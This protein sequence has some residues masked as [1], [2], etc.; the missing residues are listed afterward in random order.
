ML[1]PLA[2]WLDDRTGSRR[3]LA[4]A[5][6]LR[7]TAAARWRN[8]IG[9][10]FAILF[11]IEAFTGLL[12][13]LAYSPSSSTA[14]GSVL[15]IDHA[16]WMGWFIRG[17][18]Y[19]AGQAMVILGGLYLLRALWSRAYHRPREFNWW[20]GLILLFLAVSLSR[21][22]HL[23]PWDQEGY[24]STK[25]ETNIA[26]GVPIAGPYVQKLVVGGD[27]YGN[28]TVTRFHAA[29]VVL[30][31]VLLAV[32]LAAQ[33]ALGRRQAVAPPAG[34]STGTGSSW[35][36]HALKNLVASLVVLAVVI[37]IV[38]ARGG[39][40]L[41]APADPT[42]GDYPAR[43]DWYFL[44]LF[45]LLRIFPSELR[46]VATL[47]I[48][49]AIVAVLF[50]IPLL[51]RLLPRGLAHVLACAV[52]VA[53]L[54]GAGYLSWRALAVDAADAHYHAA[55]QEADA[56]RDRA[57]ALA[58]DPSA[59]VPPEGSTF[60][61]RLDPLTRGRGVL[62][63]KCLGCHVLDGKGQGEQTASDLARFGSREWLTGMLKDPASK[64]YF[65]AVAGAEGMV[66]WKRTSKL[67][68]QELEQVVDFV[69]LF[70]SIPDDLTPDEWL[71]RKEIAD[72][73]GL[74]LFH[75][76][77]GTCHVVE[78]LCEGGTRDA[79]GLFAWGSHRWIE[80]MVR[81]P[82]ALDR[83]GYLEPKHQM[84]PFAAEQVS[85]RD[86]EMVVRFLKGDYL[87]PAAPR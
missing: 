79:P 16:L 59:G 52:V 73:P 66:E 9:P 68:P 2:D 69:A 64:T 81:K 23:L 53:L 42:S 83:Y 17:V 35:L 36:E 84:P 27:E 47:V 65:G 49:G 63:K 24:W 85:S 55:R 34:E 74:P 25:I 38:L 78:G 15:Y 14:W 21:T 43:P 46:L 7:T 50:L 62:E 22:G 8:T 80:R 76:D 39:A 3:L 32:C 20:L 40:E 44:W 58:R 10:V 6:D 75:K 67:K 12:L 56:A 1:K 54:G 29:H 19:F 45:Q 18:H 33:I 57:I 72:H 77:C 5:L 28:L 61:L 70:P 26:G 51:D 37:G 41:E 82:A 4:A 11:V 86:L 30:L 31:P 48:P 87:K 60:L 13:M 71:S